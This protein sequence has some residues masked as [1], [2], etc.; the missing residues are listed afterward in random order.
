[1]NALLVASGSGP[2]LIFE[3]EHSSLCSYMQAIGGQIVYEDSLY[4]E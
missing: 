2:L 3:T 4:T 1:M